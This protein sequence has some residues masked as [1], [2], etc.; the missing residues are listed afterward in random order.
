MTWV[1]SCLDFTLKKSNRK[2][3]LEFPYRVAQFILKYW[4]WLRRL[5]TVDC[6]GSVENSRTMLRF[7]HLGRLPSFTD[8][9][10]QTMLIS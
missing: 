8:G 6:K 9:V 4:T 3:H 10:G 5:I 7:L 1:C 2:E